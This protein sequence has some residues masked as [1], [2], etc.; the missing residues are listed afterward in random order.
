MNGKPNTYNA[1]FQ[2]MGRGAPPSALAYANPNSRK[3]AMKNMAP[4]NATP[5]T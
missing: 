4:R 3:S 5:A 2:D 1:A